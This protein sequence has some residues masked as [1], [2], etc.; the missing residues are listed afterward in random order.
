MK[1]VYLALIVAVLSSTAFADM[2]DYGY[3]NDTT[4]TQIG[5]TTYGND[6][7]SYTRIGNTTYGNDGSSYTTIGN[8]TYG[9]DGSSCTQI[10]SQIYCR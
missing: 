5:N 2:Y 8:T 1:K 4:Y 7:S 9:S 6:G 10:G 3:S